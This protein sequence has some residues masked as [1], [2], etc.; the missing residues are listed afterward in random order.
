M[1]RFAS[2][3]HWRQSPY[4]A[5]LPVRPYH[6]LRKTIENNPRAYRA[7]RRTTAFRRGFY[8]RRHTH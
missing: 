2:L 5:K 6:R 7:L 3:F 1:D 4:L 8:V